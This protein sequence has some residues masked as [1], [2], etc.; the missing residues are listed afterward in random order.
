MLS[1]V[2]LL[3]SQT[4][5]RRK[6]LELFSCVCPHQSVCA[7]CSLI[8]AC[9]ASRKVVP[10]ADI[11]LFCLSSGEPSKTVVVHRHSIVLSIVVI[12]QRF[13][14]YRAVLLSQPLAATF[15][16]NDSRYKVWISLLML[17]MMS[18]KSFIDAIPF[19]ITLYHFYINLIIE[20]LLNMP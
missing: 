6:C 15:P 16:R 10:V 9:V 14:P 2:S 19:C 3:L 12:V 11:T 18:V 20:W 17:P 5:G 7:V 8:C 13:L 4:P 1:E